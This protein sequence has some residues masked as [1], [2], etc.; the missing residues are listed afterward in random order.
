MFEQN[1]WSNCRRAAA[2]HL[3]D[4]LR[5]QRTRQRPVR[6]N[7]QQQL[8][9]ASNAHKRKKKRKTQPL[10]Q[11]IRGGVGLQRHRRRRGHPLHQRPF[12]R[13]LSDL[14]EWNDSPSKFESN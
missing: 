10:P 14:L 11:A 2:A 1:D 4:A 6:S 9:D 12:R 5:H 3:E 7:L 13:G 8:P